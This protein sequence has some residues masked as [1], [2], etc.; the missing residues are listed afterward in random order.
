METNKMQN[1]IS[2]LLMYFYGGTTPLQRYVA[3]LSSA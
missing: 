2:G 1:I 3:Q